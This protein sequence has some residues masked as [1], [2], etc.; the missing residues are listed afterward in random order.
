MLYI[1]K[2]VNDTVPTW[3]IWAKSVSVCSLNTGG[4]LTLN[5]G[6]SKLSSAFTGEH[7]ERSASRSRCLK[8]RNV[9]F[10]SVIFKLCVFVSQWLVWAPW[11]FRILCCLCFLPVFLWTSA[12]EHSLLLWALCGCSLLLGFCPSLLGLYPLCENFVVFKN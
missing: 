9:V 7:A 6:S 4:V 3:T 11:R 1:V 10:T 8:S 5:L 2:L 12:Y